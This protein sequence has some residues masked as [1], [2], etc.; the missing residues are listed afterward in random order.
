MRDTPRIPFCTTNG[1]VSGLKPWVLGGTSI[2]WALLAMTGAASAQARGSSGPDGAAEVGE[3]VVTGTSI[4]GIKPVGS[5]TVPLSKEDI[6]STGL[7]N[8]ADVVRTLPQLQNIGIDET[9]TGGSQDAGTNNGRGTALNLRGLGSNA[10]LMLIDGRRLAPSGTLSAFGDPNQIP[11]AALERIEVVTDGASAIYGTDAVGG[12]VNFI[13]KKNYDGFEVTG[14]YTTTDGYDQ[15]GLSA[16]FGKVW[17]RGNVIL[18]YDHDDRSRM[19]RGKVPYLRQDLRQF[20]GN[21]GRINGATITPGASPL[22]VVQTGSTFN[23]YA[24]PSGSNGVGLTASQ[25]VPGIPTVVDSA[26]YVDY[27]PHRTRTSLTGFANYEVTDKVSVYWEGF[28]NIRDSRSRGYRAD[29]ILLPA[30]NRFYIPGIPGVAPGASL[31]VRYALAKDIGERITLATERSSSNT[32]GMKVVL[33]AE[34][35]ADAYFTHGLAKNCQCEEGEKSGILNTTALRN[36]LVANDPLFNPFSPTPMD[37]TT[38]SR[39]LGENLLRNQTILKDGVIKFDGPLFAIPGG[40]VRAAIGGEYLNI[41]GNY[42]NAGT[43]TR[44]DNLFVGT[45]SGS[46]SRTVKA[47]FAELFVPVVGQDNALPLV[48]RLDLSMATRY[49]KY[50]DFGNTNNPKIGVTWD[51]TDDLSIRGTVGRSFRAPSLQENNEDV[52]TTFILTTTNNNARDPAIPITNTG[53][54]Q[55]AILQ[56]TGGNAGLTPEKAKTYSVG[57]DYSPHW[58]DGL[59]L[60]AT[61]YNIKYTDKIVGLNDQVG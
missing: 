8:T 51:P 40:Q 1:A 43:T 57:F 16:V 44:P 30:S 42:R 31:S 5:A 28:L 48:K 36:L 27:L 60:S 3:V 15:K 11:V 45:Y 26:D 47:A 9:R 55:S 50:S 53:T 21:D 25:L 4:R 56:R 39:V 29:T 33:P 12:V 7:A 52:V 59:R 18:A 20:G 58:L 38:R 37:A 2:A 14:R 6:L 19:L 61:Y 32:V 17:D 35:S 22:I 13:L 41:V 46:K 34:W 24:L 23:Y 49:E 10:T 54:G